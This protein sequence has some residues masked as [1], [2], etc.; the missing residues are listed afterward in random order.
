MLKRLGETARHLSENRELAVIGA[1]SGMEVE[2]ESI[3]TM[4]VLMRD[5]FPAEDERKHHDR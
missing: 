1:L 3:R 4:M 5:N 2:V